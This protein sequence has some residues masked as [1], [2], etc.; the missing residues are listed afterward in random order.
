MPRF[1]PSSRSYTAMRHVVVVDDSPT[2][3]LLLGE[4]VEALPDATAHAFGTSLEALAWSA[5]HDVDCFVIDFHMPAPNGLEMTRLLRADPKHHEVP[6]VMVT[7][8]SDLDTRTQVLTAGANDFVMRPVR[9]DE[10]MARL[11]TLLALH[12]AR[13]LLALRVEELE[14]SLVDSED[15]ARR[16][17]RRLEALWRIANNPSLHGEQLVQ[18]MLS[19]AAAALRPGEDF[20]GLLGRIEGK[21]VTLLAVAPA[22]GVRVPTMG[23]RTATAETAIVNQLKAG[24]TRAWEDLDSAGMPHPLGWKSVISTQF[25]AGDATY[26]MTFASGVR[27]KEPFGS[28]DFAYLKVIGTFFAHR[29]QLD[30]LQNVLRDSEERSREHAD[31]LEAF[32]RIVNNPQLHD[33]ELWL[34]MLRGGAASI[35]PGMWYR[36]LLARVEGD[37]MIVESI[38][39]PNAAA[40][41]TARWSIGSAV[42]LRETIAGQ[43]IEDGGGTRS[44]DESQLRTLAAS[45]PQANPWG[46]YI[47]TT[48]VAGGTTYILAFAALEAP[49]KPFGEQ[50][51]AYI[52]VLASFFASRLQQNWQFDRIQYQQSHDVLTGL[53]NRSQFRSRARMLNFQTG[54]ERYALLLLD[55][56]ALRTVNETYG[57]MIGDALLVEVATGLRSRVRGDEFAGRIGG[58]V[59]GIFIPGAT[60]AKAVRRARDFSSVFSKP[61]STGDRDG[62]EFIALS[63]SIGLALAPEDG[64]DLDT[65]FSHADAALIE[66][67]KR[68]PGSIFAYAIEIAGR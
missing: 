39:E 14:E 63:A 51:D 41:S 20:S 37:Q 60:R 64:R 54:S 31:R 61:F 21:H 13:K 10:L 2:N 6:I 59:F 5:D 18:A 36:G 27:T 58:D 9:R 56:N 50:D 22:D 67:K 57:H 52:E 49:A 48:F 4:L 7:G 25:P 24:R 38:T 62:K 15:R 12:D 30:A 65:I 66:A 55:V 35:R 43:L 34:A 68:G 11:M 53:L 47:A 8:E 32:S 29:L 17:A 3:L 16:H 42:L 23:T 40:P 26:S 1:V 45:N 33:A 46:S 19:Q 28:D 44:W